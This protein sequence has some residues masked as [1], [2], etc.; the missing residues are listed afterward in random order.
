MPY[1]LIVKRNNS[2]QAL[3]CLVTAAFCETEL[4]VK[5]DE[6]SKDLLTFQDDNEKSTLGWSTFMN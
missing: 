5:L 2:Y 3:K 6:T 1:T 4:K